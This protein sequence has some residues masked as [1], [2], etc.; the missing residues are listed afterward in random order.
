MENY[1]KVNIGDC[2]QLSAQ[3]QDIDD[4]DPWIYLVIDVP[5]RTSYYDDRVTLVC[6]YNVVSQYVGEIIKLS[7]SF[8]LNKM[9]TKI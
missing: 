6:L 4:A 9:W 8:T 3:S 1:L 5:N 2:V 7:E